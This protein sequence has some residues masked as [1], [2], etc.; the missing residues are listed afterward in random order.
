MAPPRVVIVGAGF[1]GYQAAKALSRRMRDSAE[2]VVVN[3]TDYMLYLPLLPEVAAGTLDPRTVAV[4]LTDKLPGVKLALGSARRINPA[5]HTLVYRDPED[6][7]WEIGY[8]RLL[9]T[10]GSTHRPLPIEGIAEHGHGVRSLAEALYLRD[11]VV[12]QLELAAADDDAQE[13]RARCTIV[14]VGAG[15]TGTE[16]AAAGQLMTTQLARDHRRLRDTPVRWLLL[17]AAPQVLPGMGD[18]MSAAA[19]RILSRRG[20]EIRTGTS[21]RRAGAEGV[22]LTD[23]TFV[24]TRTIVW[25]V[26]V[27]PDPLVA[28]LG[29]E[30][31]QQGRIKVDEYLNVPGHPDIYACGDAAAAPDLTRPGGVTA[32]NGQHAERQGTRAGLNIAASLGLGVAKPYR[33]HDLGFVVDMAG[34]Q[35]VA[36]PLGIPLSGIAA[37]AVTAAYHLYAVPANR[38]RIA[39]A[40]LVNALSPRQSVQLGLAQGSSIP[41]NPS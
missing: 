5:A 15:Y 23:D 2:V 7:E 28:G 32:M 20:V 19:T 3:P 10:V 9:L 30:L 37:K 4:S 34:W 35:A 22:W 6:R 17:D 11:H 21:V 31:T 24:P 38:R 41:L 33:H 1:A 40:W 39:A 26:G 25:A 27:R 18:R 14:V 13:R 12:S 16:I 29:L 8:D 36:N